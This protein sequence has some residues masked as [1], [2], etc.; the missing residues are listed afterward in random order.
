VHHLVAGFLDYTPP[1]PETDDDGDDNQAL[2]NPSAWLGGRG[3]LPASRELAEASTPEE[4]LAAA[5]RM[6][7]GEV[8]D[9]KQL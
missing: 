4:A 5:E 6:F 8:K 9:V 1:A 3:G 7:F 2:G